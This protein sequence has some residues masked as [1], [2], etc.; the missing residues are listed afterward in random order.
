[1]KT[2]AEGFSFGR[3]HI[4]PRLSDYAQLT[5]AR[6]TTLIIMTAWCGFFFGARK[7]G[8]PAMSWSLLHALLGI[9]MVSSG[10]AALNEVMEHEVDAK[11]RRTARRPIP[12]GRMSLSHATLVGGMLTVGGSIYLFLFTNWLT[13]FLTF[14]TSAVYL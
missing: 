3:L 12:T 8:L 2:A 10:T 9:G 13:G 7:A 1:M 5:K 4:M 6:V 11:M 14:L